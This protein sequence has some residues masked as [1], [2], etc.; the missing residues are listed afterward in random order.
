MALGFDPH[1]GKS[2]KFRRQ[3]RKSACLR[4]A[5]IKGHRLIVTAL[6]AI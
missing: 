1:A 3:A 4:Q 5:D 2:G 6:S